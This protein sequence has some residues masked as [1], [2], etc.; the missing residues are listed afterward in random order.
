ME[1]KTAGLPKDDSFG[2]PGFFYMPYNQQLDSRKP[3]MKVYKVVK[4]LSCGLLSLI[5]ALTSCGGDVGGVSVGSGGT[6]STRKEGEV[7][8]RTSILT[9][10]TISPTNPLG[11]NSGTQLQFTA[12]GSY[13]DNSMRDLTTL[14]VWTS[15]DPSV[16]TVS[17][18][19][20]S[21]GM[22]TAVSRGYCSISAKSGNISGSTIIGVY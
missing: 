22:V 21:I 17:N 10:L 12:K 8:R 4:I 1:D 18:E 9:S 6:P 11:I 3:R 20:A 14:V 16:A 13:S 19:P 15:S 7:S 5:L 2:M